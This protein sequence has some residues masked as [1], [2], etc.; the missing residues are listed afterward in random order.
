MPHLKALDGPVFKAWE[1]SPC[2]LSSEKQKCP[3]LKAKTTEN[4]M[5]CILP[6]A[7][8]RSWDLMDG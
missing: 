5:T 4:C 2:D 6:T 3:T 7:S 1:T 8:A